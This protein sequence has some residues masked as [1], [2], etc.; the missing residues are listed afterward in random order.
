MTEV[1]Q[2][3]QAFG[4][5]LTILVAL[6]LWLKPWAEKAMVAHLNFLTSTS[7]TIRKM[8]GGFAQIAAAVQ[9]MENVLEQNDVET[10]CAASLGGSE[11][12]KIDQG[13]SLVAKRKHGCPG[14]WR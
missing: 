12:S 3:L 14:A 5:P 11:L 1:L 2:L 8:E 10:G 13:R 9:K 7:E 6:V 4:L